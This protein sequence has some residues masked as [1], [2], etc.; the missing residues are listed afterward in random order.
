MARFIILE[1]DHPVLHW[2]FMLEAGEALQ[3]WRL[4]E[5]PRPRTT[6]EAARIFDHRLFYLDYEGPVR[7]DRGRVTRWDGG[8]FAWETREE[9]RVVVRLVGQRLR[10]VMRLEG[11]G[12][13]VWRAWFVPEGQPVRPG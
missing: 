3:T 8:T 2:D 9:R 11:E 7:G 10:G 5:P 4:N 12:G 13:D 6:V 1:H